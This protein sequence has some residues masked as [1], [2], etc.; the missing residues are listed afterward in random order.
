[1]GLNTIP[2]NAWPLSSEQVGSGGGGSQYELPIASADT[3][4]GVKVGTGL[5][6][7]SETGVLANSNPTPY[8][9]PI[10][11][12]ET[13]G[14]VKVGTGLSINSETGVLSNPNT[15]PTVETVSYTLDTTKC[16]ASYVEAYKIGNIVF[17]NCEITKIAG[18]W[19]VISDLP[20]PLTGQHQFIGTSI[21]TD[22]D[23]APT[24]CYV[25]EEGLLAIKSDVS[26]T[27]RASIVYLTIPTT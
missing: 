19:G 11:G 17:L 26:G 27:F 9:L 22:S 15:L 2:A 18:G 6:I 4:G 10:A 21:K 7:N 8:S 14:G 24:A 16:T 5:S 25:T 1:M 20:L 13:L 23:N 3:L 12:A